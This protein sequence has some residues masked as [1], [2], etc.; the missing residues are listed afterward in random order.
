MI[1]CEDTTKREEMYS[2]A[3]Q[4]MIRSHFDAAVQ[5]TGEAS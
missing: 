1:N 5:F 4:S 2:H 3:L